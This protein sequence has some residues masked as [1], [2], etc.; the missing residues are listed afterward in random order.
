M[1]RSCVCAASG[2]QLRSASNALKEIVTDHL[3]ALERVWDER[4]R[5]QHGPLVSRLHKLFD[6]FQICGD[7]HFGFLRLRCPGCR[8]ELIL[9]FSCKARS[10]CPSCAQ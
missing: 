6:A 1:P 3:E 7:P 2:D 5:A 10:L 8:N 4:F 9:P